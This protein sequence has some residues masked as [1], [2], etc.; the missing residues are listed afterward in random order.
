MEVCYIRKYTRYHKRP[1]IFLGLGDGIVWSDTK[2]TN[3][4]KKTKVCYDRTYIY[5]KRAHI[6]TGLGDQVFVKT[7]I[8]LLRLVV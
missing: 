1:R 8:W 7:S 3:L 2:K 6:F 4:Q 5:H